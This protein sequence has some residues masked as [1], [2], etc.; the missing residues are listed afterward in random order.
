MIYVGLPYEYKVAWFVV[1]VV[2]DVE[3]LVDR[4]DWELDVEVTPRVTPG[5]F[6]QIR[7]MA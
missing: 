3:G 6:E 5:V 4:L 7:G 1:E 2:L